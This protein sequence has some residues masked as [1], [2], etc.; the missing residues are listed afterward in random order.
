MST[1][2]QRTIKSWISRQNAPTTSERVL[3]EQAAANGIFFPFGSALDSLQ[4][5]VLSAPRIYLDIGFGDGQSLMQLADFDKEAFIIG[6]EPHL[7][8]VIHALRVLTAQQRSNVRLACRD[9]YDFFN[10]LPAAS[11]DRVHIYF[12]DPW[13][14]T[15]HHKR[16]LIQK[17]IW[18]T[19]QPLLKKTGLVHIATDWAPYARMIAQELT[20]L[21]DWQVSS[22]PKSSNRFIRHP[23][24]YERKAIHEGRSVAEFYVTLQSL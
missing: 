15:R 2:P 18:D 19:L 8:G 22:E 13:P 7:P 11:L 6:V 1:I 20:T 3:M 17:N 16:R 12:S 10:I 5:E 9:V 24:K 4:T 23:T 14:K 21:P